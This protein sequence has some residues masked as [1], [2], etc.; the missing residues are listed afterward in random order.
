MY[1]MVVRISFGLLKG[2]SSGS[3]GFTTDKSKLPVSTSPIDR[4]HEFSDSVL[5][6]CSSIKSA[7]SFSLRGLVFQDSYQGLTVTDVFSRLSFKE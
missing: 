3:F 7:R 5:V 4:F 6:F 2:A 1:E